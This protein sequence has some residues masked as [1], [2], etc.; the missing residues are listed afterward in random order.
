MTAAI[1][2]ESLRALASD[3]AREA[4]TLARQRRAEGVR[5]AATK[6]SLADIVTEADREVEDLI[7]AR[8][9]DARPGDGFLGEES[10]ADASTTGLTWVVDPIDGTVNYAYGFG[11]YAVSIAAVE[12]ADVGLAGTRGSG[13]TLA[14]AVYAPALGELFHAARGGGAV[15]EG[16]HGTIPLRVN[17]EAPAAG[18]LAGTG[19]GYDPARRTD[20]LARL[21]RVM[22]LLRD[23]RRMG[24]AALDLAAVAAG[25]LDAYFEAGLWAW[26]HAAGALLVHEAGGVVRGPHGGR[27]SRALTLAAHPEVIAPLAA[28]LDRDPDPAPGLRP[29]S[30]PD[31]AP[32]EPA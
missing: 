6:S 25:R 24:S 12:G 8:L 14:G 29:D 21:E 31:P 4:G 2:A 13:E 19:F 22:P 23:I 3:I 18:L 17:D 10:G 30:A 20:D 5:V 28:L 15:L 27:E 7:R 32:R 11:Q 9:R 16:A 26:D 1:D